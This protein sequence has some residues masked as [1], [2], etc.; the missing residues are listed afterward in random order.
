MLKSLSAVLAAGLLVSTPV[1]A[2]VPASTELPLNVDHFM[3]LCLAI[4]APDWTMCGPGYG[5]YEGD[6]LTPVQVPVAALEKA[7]SPHA[8]KKKRK[9]SRS[10]AS[11]KE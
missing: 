9:A 1:R 7:K 2:G 6:R 5:A 10:L 4:N 3:E 8:S 11:T